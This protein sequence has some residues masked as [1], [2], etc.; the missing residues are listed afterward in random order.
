MNMQ[1]IDFGISGLSDKQVLLSREKYGTAQ[2]PTA[3]RP[4]IWLI[5][6]SLIK[7]P[8]V[9]LLLITGAIYFISG[10]PS[11]GLFLIFAVLIIS[12]ISIFQNNRSQK[13]LAELKT[14]TI[15]PCSVIRNGELVKIPACDIV[16]GDALVAEEG[17]TIAADGIVLKSNDFSV[18]E[19]A[20][21]GE[22]LPVF[23]TRG[24]GKQQ[25]FMGTT[26]STG[27]A[28]IEVNAIGSATALGKIGRDIET[29]K[30]E[31]SPLELQLNNFVRKM[32]YIGVVVFII[33]FGFHL[34]RSRDFLVSILQSL[35]LAMSILPEEIPVAFASFMA[36]GAWALMKKS[37]IVKEIKTVETLGSASVICTD[38][39]GTL[40]ENKMDIAKV[41]ICAT[42]SFAQGNAL[43]E[44]EAKMLIRLGMWASEPIPFDPMDMALHQAYSLSAAHDERSTYHMHHE[45]PL[46][47]SP[48]MMT[49]I[50]ENDKGERIIASKGAPEAYLN[51]GMVSGEVMVRTRAALSLLAGQGYRVL[52]LASSAFKGNDFPAA[53]QS[54]PM[55]LIGLIAFYDPPKKNIAAVI[56]GFYRAGIQVKIVTGDNALTTSAI[57]SE[58]GLEGAEKYSDGLELLKLN[59]AELIEKAGSTVLFTR[60]F[61]QAKL[62]LVNALKERGETVAMVGDGVNDG[63][64]LKAAHIGIA[65]GKKG[66][67]IAKA[68]AALVLTGDDLSGMLDAIAIGRRIYDNLKKA[69]RYIISIHIPI[70][71]T[72]ALPLMLGWKYSN[73][74][75]PIH[76]IFFELIMGPTCSIIYEQEPMEKNAMS[77]PPR[78]FSPDLFTARELWGSIIQGLVISLGIMLLYRYSLSIGYTEAMTRTMIFSAMVMS[79]MVLTLVN[80]SFYYSILTTLGYKNKLVALILVLTL[81]L[82]LVILY[83]KPVN[84][85]FGLDIPGAGQLFICFSVAVL[86]VGWIEVFKWYKRRTAES[87]N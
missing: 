23:R 51:P 79:N 47:G 5:L 32:V 71:L 10:K 42:G 83:L 78:L 37:I 43:K 54:L 56:K 80:R 11:D 31:K 13:A 60:M 1:R 77:R 2:L 64:A 19:S 25:L 21:T 28:V 59:P 49:H 44:S 55:E 35:S 8:M 82:L 68:A 86:S 85:F 70:I 16:I 52:G 48:P 30:Q 6:I 9:L 14:F 33:V 22:S 3:V 66:T 62:A 46:G 40:T 72:V 7:E 17:A 18:D 4:G 69:V 65:M 24:D 12:G 36:L 57:A 45:Y 34:Y 27:L 20:M 58:I 81:L 84:D 74:F 39:T 38:K 61:P 41:F 75:S 87:R 26:V 53:Q 63:P 76:I 67:D 73:I 15:P 29:I 50:F